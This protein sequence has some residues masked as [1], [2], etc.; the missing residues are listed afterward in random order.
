MEGL[1]TVSE[2]VQR[3]IISLYKKEY[4]INNGQKH[5]DNCFWVRE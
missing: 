1:V 2:D 3:P 5:M 4:N